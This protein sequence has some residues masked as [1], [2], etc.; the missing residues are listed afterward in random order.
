MGAGQLLPY[1]IALRH[2]P[3]RHVLALGRRTTAERLETDTTALVRRVFDLAGRLGCGWSEPVLCLMSPPDGPMA[4]EVCLAVG[5][6]EGEI[7]GARVRPLP[8][9]PVAVTRHVGPYATLGLAHHALVAWA[10]ER[11][12]DA[13]GPLREAYLNDPDEVDPDAL[14]T[15]VMLPIAGAALAGLGA[16]PEKDRS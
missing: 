6:A 7:E 15:E 14:V 12:L 4:I 5:C 2:E 10:Q 8:G 1:S 13:T 3:D 11:G 16:T 9:G